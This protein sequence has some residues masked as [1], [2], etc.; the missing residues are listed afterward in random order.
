M[1]L[2][3]RSGAGR[4]GVPTA[5]VGRG[6]DVPEA[7]LRVVGAGD[8][9]AYGGFELTFVE[10]EH[11]PG[12]RYPGTVDAA[13]APPRRSRAWRTGTV[14]SVFVSHRCGTLLVR[15]TGA[16]RVVLVHWDDFFV[17]LDQSLR[18]MPYPADDL[19]ATLRRLSTLSAR[20]DVEVQLPV[21]WQPSDPFGPSGQA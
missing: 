6:L 20:D 9:L 13:L 15:A 8:V 12:D 11:G 3:D 1:G 18:P 7:S 4:L 10:S 17:S 14:Y 19:D 5:N 2:A 16:R 21:A